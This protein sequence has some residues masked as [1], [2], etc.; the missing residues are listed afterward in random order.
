MLA[1]SDSDPGGAVGSTSLQLVK[2]TVDTVSQID[3]QSDS[4]T[5]R[6]SDSQTVRQSDHQTD[7]QTVSQSDSQSD[8]TVRQ[9]DRDAQCYSLM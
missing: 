3:R 8:R 2:T 4:Q 1:S 5:I 9:T 6:Q 7:R